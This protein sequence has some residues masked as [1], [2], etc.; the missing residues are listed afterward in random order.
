MTI[1]QKLIAI[2][3]EYPRMSVKNL[4]LMLTLYDVG[5]ATNK[6]LVVITKG[7]THTIKNSMC[8]SIER[9]LVEFFNIGS[10]RAY[11]L[12]DEARS[13]IDE[14]FNAD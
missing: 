1:Q 8:T 10:K 7:S 14:V 6:E 13:V 3:N 12:S 9:G 2:G 11:K 4:A 5:S